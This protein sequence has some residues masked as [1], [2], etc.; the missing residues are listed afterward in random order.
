MGTAKSE[1]N[2][3]WTRRAVPAEKKGEYIRHLKRLRATRI[4]SVPV[5]GGEPMVAVQALVPR[6]RLSDLPEYARVC[7]SK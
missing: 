5:G 6:H 4:K 1:T 7:T 3:V 2:F